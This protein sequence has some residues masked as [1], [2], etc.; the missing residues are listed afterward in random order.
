M[1]GLIISVM[2]LRFIHADAFTFIA[3]QAPAKNNKKTKNNQK[4]TII[5]TPIILLI[6]KMIISN[7]LPLALAGVNAVPFRE[8]GG[9][10]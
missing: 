3:V 10:G 7:I 2:Y 4:Q 8:E 6:R 9:G 1:P 5:S